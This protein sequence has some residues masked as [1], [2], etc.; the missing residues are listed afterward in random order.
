MT[1]RKSECD[2]VSKPEKQK[3]EQ[4]V[5]WEKP[6]LFDTKANDEAQGEEH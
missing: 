6:E 3:T 4:R 1:A 2:K 5:D